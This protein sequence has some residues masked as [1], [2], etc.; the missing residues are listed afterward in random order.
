LTSEPRASLR[1]AGKG[2][3]GES[4]RAPSVVSKTREPKPAIPVER[5]LVNERSTRSTVSP[6]T[7]S[8]PASGGASSFLPASAPLVHHEALRPPGGRDARC[9][10]PT[11]ATPMTLRAPVLRAF[12]AHS[13]A[14]TAWM[15]PSCEAAARAAS[16]V[17]GSVR[18]T[19]VPSVFTTLENASADRSQ[20]RVA[21]WPRAPSH[22]V[23]WAGARAWALS[24][25][26]AF[27]DQASDT[28][29]ASPLREIRPSLRPA[30]QRS[31]RALSSLL[32]RS[33]RVRKPPRPP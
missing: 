3:A 23:R 26:G 6:S 19:G 10:R 29:V 21:D 5:T 27:C 20:T 15:P 11:S 16:G 8:C 33:T 12:P 24:S 7:G 9:V 32:R 2:R 18:R 28:S 17:L 22:R 31:R 13:A 25:H 4:P 14:F 1:L 30:L